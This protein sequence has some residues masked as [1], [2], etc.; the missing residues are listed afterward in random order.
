MKV[1]GHLVDIHNPDIY[2][3]VIS[4]KRDKVEGIERSNSAAEVYIMPGLIDA[5]IHIETSMITP[6]A[7][8]TTAVKHGT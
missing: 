8:V 3:A 2:P 7:F 5:H 4:F 6:G 1:F